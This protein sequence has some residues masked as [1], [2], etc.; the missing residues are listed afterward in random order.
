MSLAYVREGVEEGFVDLSQR[1]SE[2]T[3][4]VGGSL[5]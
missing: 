5:C 3:W 1:V 4:T 2:F